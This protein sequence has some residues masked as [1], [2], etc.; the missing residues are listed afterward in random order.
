VQKKIWIVVFIAA[1]GGGGYFVWTYLRFLVV[2][3][4]KV[5]EIVQ[6]KGGRI[7][8]PAT[9]AQMDGMIKDAAAASHVPPE[10]LSVEKTIVGRPA[11]PIVLWYLV[12][13]VTDEKGRSITSEE[14][15][16]N[17]GTFIDDPEVQKS[18]G[19]TIKK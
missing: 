12:V 11:G 9:V 19:V 16:E 5:D 8:Q 3:K 10:G 14:Q 4:M 18:A 6:K 2:F 17:S 13:T 7:P 15:I 1:L